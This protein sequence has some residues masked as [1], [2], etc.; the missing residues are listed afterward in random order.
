M[1]IGSNKRC[2]CWPHNPGHNP[3]DAIAARKCIPQLLFFIKLLFDYDSRRLHV[4][5]LVSRSRDHHRLYTDLLGPGK[6]SLAVGSA[7][8]DDRHFVWFRNARIHS[9]SMLPALVPY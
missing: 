7:G 9:V 6:D 4:L 1:H 3:C 2:L 5:K 8:A